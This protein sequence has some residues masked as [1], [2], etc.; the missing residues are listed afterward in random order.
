MKKRLFALVL[1]ALIATSLT[2]CT[3]ADAGNTTNNAEVAASENLDSQETEAS[4]AP[5]A[6]A[7]ITI[8]DI[9]A[10]NSRDSI[11]TSYGALTVSEH[12]YV[13]ERD[14]ET[15]YSK[16]LTYQTGPDYFSLRS[17]DLVASGDPEGKGFGCIVDGDSFESVLNSYQ[18]IDWI[19]Y[20]NSEVTLNDDNTITITGAYE[21]YIITYD[22]ESLL[23]LNSLIKNKD[24]S[25]WLNR[26]YVYSDTDRDE[27]IFGEVKGFIDEESGGE[28]VKLTIKASDGDKTFDIPLGFSATIYS[29]DEYMIEGT[30]EGYYSQP[31]EGDTTL[32]PYGFETSETETEDVEE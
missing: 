11:F 25:D 16:K 26:E 21:D 10:A 17:E 31:L 7:P 24:G 22:P 6:A 1:A 8:E 23:F 9:L 12:D 32:V 30:D 18:R 14:T 2:A 27:A 20:D 13:Q 15:Y 29:E 19:D 5:E 28:T 4:E 3:E